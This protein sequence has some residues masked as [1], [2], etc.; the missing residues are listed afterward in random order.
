[1]KKLFSLFAF[2]GTFAF[3]QEITLTPDN[4][5]DKANPEKD[6]IVLQDLGQDA[7]QLFDKTKMFILSKYK[8]SKD[9]NYSEVDGK[10]IVI[11]VKGDNEVKKIFNVGGANVYN[12]LI[13]YELKFKD[14]KV[15]VKPYFERLK[16]AYNGENNTD[17]T[18]IK[19]NFLSSGLYKKNKKSNGHDDVIK[20]I[21]DEVNKL[22][23][24]LR[25]QLKSNEDW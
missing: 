20:T 6:Y 1:M 15:M 13:R 2:V 5:R 18:L 12:T 7:K 14:G 4:F 25:K 10:S 23:E 3:C 17:V 21:N 19:E 24:D 8:G 16:N 11:D 9:R 22:I